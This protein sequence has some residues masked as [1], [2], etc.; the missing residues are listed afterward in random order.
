MLLPSPPPHS[1]PQVFKECKFST[2]T[3]SWFEGLRG[4]ALGLPWWD[5]QRS[6]IL[7]HAG[8]GAQ[9]DPHQG[10]SP[11]EASEGP[12][13]S[14]EAEPT[15]V[16]AT[17]TWQHAQTELLASQAWTSGSV[18][19]PFPL[20]PSPDLPAPVGVGPLAPLTPSCHHLHSR[21]HL[22]LP[23][24]HRLSFLDF[25]SHLA[26]GPSCVFPRAAPTRYHKLRGLSNRS[27][28]SPSSGS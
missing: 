11:R 19:L 27:L 5:L 28:L 20:S 18:T 8:T 25:S 15:A 10:Q 26:E 21:P 24:Q 13:P 7:S 2:I 4:S 22:L 3:A 23:V 6:S 17:C 14:E 12:K 16:R 9:P 1:S